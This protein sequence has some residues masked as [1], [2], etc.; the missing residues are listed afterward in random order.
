[1]KP[2]MIFFTLATV[3]LVADAARADTI[4]TTFDN[5][6]SERAL[7]FLVAPLVHDSFRPH[8]LQRHRN[9]LRQQLQVHRRSFQA[10][11]GQHTPRTDDY[12]L[13]T[14]SSRRAFGAHHYSH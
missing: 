5:F 1:M 11:G 3:L 13:R 9:G 4:V 6:T 2:C 8:Q 12:A 7:P 10:R 14:S